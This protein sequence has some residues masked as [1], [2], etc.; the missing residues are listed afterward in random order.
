M[1][2]KANIVKALTRLE[3]LNG[4]QNP[5]AKDNQGAFLG[6]VF[7]WE[8]VSDLAH[9]RAKDAWSSLSENN[10][11]PADDTLRSRITGEEVITKSPHF[12]LQVKVSQPRESFDQTL[13]IDKVAKKFSIDRHKLVELAA[14][15]KKASKA[16]LSK[17]VIEL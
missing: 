13:F 14:T 9:D 2:Y 17:R 3:S 12:V 15:C 16:P 11:I 4:T 6:P 1:S 7:F 10:L 8:T 5:D